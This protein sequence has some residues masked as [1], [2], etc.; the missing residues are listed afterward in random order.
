MNYKKKNF[1]FGDKVKVINTGTKGVDGL[2]GR[3]SGISSINIFDTF[4]ITLDNPIDLGVGVFQSFVLPETCL[5]I[6]NI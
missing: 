1:K 5:E 2:I 3:V 6:T 4:I